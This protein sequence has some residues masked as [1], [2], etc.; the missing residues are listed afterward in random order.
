MRYFL[1]FTFAGWL[2]MVAGARAHNGSLALIVPVS[3]VV[4]DGDMSDWPDDMRR[5]PIALPE[6]GDAPESKE[7]FQGSFRLGYSAGDR[8]L[9]VAVEVED[10]STVIDTSLQADWD[11]Q[12][13]CFVY[14]DIHH[15]GVESSSREFSVRG[16]R[17][18]SW[19]GVE[20]AVQRV[21][22]IHRYE[23]RIGADALGDEAVSWDTGTA[24]GIDVGVTDQD[25]D[26]SF[27]WM[28]W[29]RGLGKLFSGSRLGDAALVEHDDASGIIEGTIQ[30]EDPEIGGAL[31]RVRIGRMPHDLHVE[32]RTDTKGRYAV[33]VPPG[34]YQVEAGYGQGHLAVGE[35]I[36]RAGDRVNL[37][38][39]FFPR[40]E[41]GSVKKA[42]NG[43][44]VQAGAGYDK[45]L[46]HTLQTTDGLASNDVSSLLEDRIGR[47]WIGTADGGLSRYDGNS[48]ITFT[49]DDGLPGAVITSLLE[50]RMG[51]LWVGTADGGLSRY[52]GDSFVTFTAADG[53]PSND[54][55]SLLEDRAGVVWV[56]TYGAGLSRYDGVRFFSVTTEDGLA[57]NDVSALLEDRFGRVW[58]G[59]DGGVS[60]YDG[61]EFTNYT[62]ADGL[63]GSEVSSLL[64][65]RAGHLWIGTVDGGLSRYDGDQFMAYSEEEVGLEG[66]VV[67]TLL[68]DRIGRIWIGTADGGLSCYD[69]DRFVSYAEADGL[70]GIQVQAL[71]EDRSGHL[72]I[73]AW[74]GLSRYDGG[75]FT[76]YSAADSLA[77]NE[78]TILWEDRSGDIWVGTID[79]GLSRYD[80]EGFFSYTESGGLVGSEVVD[81]LED[82]TGQIW[83]GTLDGGISQYDRARDAFKK[84]EYLDFLLA[85][86]ALTCIVEDRSGNI[87]IGTNR[88][89]GRYDGTSTVVYTESDGLA[90]NNVQVVLADESGEVWIGTWGGGLSRFDGDSFTTYT[91]ADGLVSN[92]VGVLLRDRS[93]M[94]WIGTNAGL[95]RYDG[96]DF[97]NYSVADGMASNNVQAL[98]QDRSGLLW[99]STNGGISQFDGTVFQH[100]LR[101]DGL[102]G[103]WV[104]D[105]IEDRQGQMWIAT[106]SG[107]VRYRPPRTA[108]P[109][110]IKNIVA[111]RAYGPVASVR[112]PSSQT[113]VTFEFSGISYRT[114]PNQMAYVYRLEGFES[115]WQQ[116]RE[117]QVSYTNLQPGT[118]RFTVK[119]VD[120]DLN[121]SEQPATVDVEVFYQ[122]VTSSIRILDLDVQDIFA[123]FYKTYT[124][125]SIGSV[126]VINDGVVPLEAT[127][128]FYIPSHMQRPVEQTVVLEPQS[129]QMVP[130]FA[131]FNEEILDIDEAMP[132]Q[133]EVSLSY[134]FDDQ[135]ISLQKAK[136]I[137]VYG[138][139]DLTWDS[140]GRAAAFVTSQ[141]NDVATFSRTLYEAYRTR[142][143]EGP[144]NGNIPI[145][146]LLFEAL[147][148]H[149]IQY[150]K[151]TSTPYSQ[152]RGNRSAI[153]NIQYPAELLQSKRGD[154]DDCTV[155]YCSLLENLDI[156]TAF[157]D[158][159]NH[160]LMMFDSGIGEDRY[161]GFSLDE[162]LYV[163]RGGRFWIPVEVTKLGEGSF[164]D[165]WE[166]GAATYSR[167]KDPEELV[168]DVRAVWLDYPY[169]LP[170]V[171]GEVEAPDARLLERAFVANMAQLQTF[172]DRYI[173][174]TY[175]RPLLEKPANYRLRMELAYTLLEAGDYNN[176]ISTLMHLLETDVRAEAYNL[177]A[178]CYAS[179]E[180]YELAAL[181]M[182]K[183]VEHSP[184]HRMYERRL[185]VLK[186]QLE[187]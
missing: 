30:W 87:W 174:R 70:A 156:P 63:P 51:R 103:N 160:I 85:D 127:L 65:D 12:D 105:V 62:A 162:D 177:I 36:V 146:M 17:A 82:S 77:G 39:A 140:L 28:V 143:A 38:A 44:R 99:I 108:P 130:L 115:D 47:L 144:M 90:N 126:R 43:R 83:L 95:S 178:I 21:D 26:G 152:V 120:R 14:I 163:E 88:G 142:I 15:A 182:G 170:T 80:G 110:E 73:G 24:L 1:L 7:D 123:S 18:S 46:W 111:D 92:E 2:G 158:H 6:S 133:A 122:P 25:E 159:P 86:N 60:R 48:F 59:T 176:A 171:A 157:I 29:G 136:N 153:D 76:F 52:D 22:G 183:A 68:E 91:V 66:R 9:Y 161:F 4:V 121:Y 139:G 96:E 175:I 154:C 58:I 84:S 8:S 3:G 151:D 141:D 61:E 40:A 138:R 72:W 118:Y 5:Y 167:L 132:A 147:N 55:L 119:A 89:L 134:E 106:S 137:T 19:D 23:W 109:I 75:H 69:G 135:T 34:S 42:G 101:Q 168:T 53:L 165:A 57:G 64:E 169:A 107:L 148:A 31:G 10:A 78:V 187:E 93:G 27:T 181:Y 16:N 49:A 116:T 185:A 155:L 179:L 117:Q 100:L 32:I 166:L 164:I 71:L 150:A 125:R 56:G 94:L 35:E 149:G 74:G 79:G 172:R 128:R 41:L 98:L 104:S 67:L 113:L 184:G 173:E 20:A 81:L 112:I 186:S 145:A 180:N 50:D 129:T 131:L 124:E 97:V 13:G 102:P 11:T 54:V 114:R 33:E 45:G 37:G